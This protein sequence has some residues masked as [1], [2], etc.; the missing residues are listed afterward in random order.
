VS[1][2][3]SSERVGWPADVD[4]RVPADYA[5]AHAACDRWAAYPARRALLDLSDGAPRWWTFADVRDASRRFANAL[6]A[7]GVRFGDRVAIAL[8]Q[9]ADAALAHL[10]V[11]RLGAVAVPISLMHREEA[12]AQR[13]SDSGAAVAITTA[14]HWAAFVDGSAVA[15][16]VTWLRTGTPEYTAMTTTGSTTTPVV[17]ITAETPAVIVY[18]SGTTGAPKGV[19]HAHRVVAA[20]AAPISLAHDG[21]PHAGDLLWSPADWAWAGGLVD[22]LLSAWHA[23]VPIVA[24]RARRFDPDEVLDLIARHGVRN[25][26]LPA[27]ALRLLR[28][29]DRKATLRTIMT[30]GEPVDEDIVAW[31]TGELGATPNV[32]FGQTEASCV[33]GNSHSVLPQ[34]PGALGVAYPGA[35][36]AVLDP[37]GTAECAPD[38]LGEIAVRA[39]SPAVMLGY[40]RREAD[41]A[42]KVVD[43]WLRTGDLGRRDADGYFW[44]TA[45]ADDLIISSGYRIG[46]VEIES[47]LQADPRVAEVAVVG[48][49]DAERG[50]VVCALVVPKDGVERS[51]ALADELRDRVRGRLATYE[52]PRV[53]E[54]LDALPRTTTGKVQRAAIR[55]TGE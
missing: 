2:E 1:S 34:R 38:E 18:T 30:G 5:I 48:R 10:A 42:A 45:R 37:D 31:A 9:S 46:P 21:F 26:F 44:F 41:T 15:D 33:V 20:H 40:W 27:T 7:Q 47:C 39:D 55:R 28:R 35:E 3:R 14:E 6:A 50:Q 23:G 19:V 52:V 24:H 16:G 43:G 51:A 12:I 25:A 11:Y 29:S 8:P 49:A 22:C 54:F 13:L 36:V 32:V 17:P 53:V 4:A